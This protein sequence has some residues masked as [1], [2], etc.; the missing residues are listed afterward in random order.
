MGTAEPA[1]VT[2]PQAEPATVEAVKK[3]RVFASPPNHL[4]GQPPQRPG[5]LGGDV[6]GQ[7]LDSGSEGHQDKAV[8]VGVV[9]P[10]L[11]ILS[12]NVRQLI[13]RGPMGSTGSGATSPGSL[14]GALTPLRTAQV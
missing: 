7:V 6:L 14:T 2:V 11:Q 10:A 1:R 12:T 9:H 5:Q 8:F 4:L 3:R 13:L